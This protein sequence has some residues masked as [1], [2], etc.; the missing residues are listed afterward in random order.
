MSRGIGSTHEHAI[1][2]NSRCSHNLQRVDS[3]IQSMTV[4][5]AVM[6]FGKL[7][8]GP[9]G[10]MFYALQ[11]RPS[12][13]PA[14]AVRSKTSKNEQARFNEA[15]CVGDLACRHGASKL[16]PGREL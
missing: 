8:L 4:D 13:F 6:V 10:F 15:E 16:L 9:V 2:T 1:G 14:S 3:R 12:R 5:D 7:T 11:R